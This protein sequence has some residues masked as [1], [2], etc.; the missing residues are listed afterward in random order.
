MP[1]DELNA[2]LA[3]MKEIA[4]VRRQQQQQAS[5]GKRRR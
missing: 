1:R 2:Y 5:K 3:D 4:K